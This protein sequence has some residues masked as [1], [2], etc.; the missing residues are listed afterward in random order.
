MCKWSEGSRTLFLFRALLLPQAGQ[1]GPAGEVDASF[2]SAGH[3][4]WWMTLLPK[5][6]EYFSG[7]CSVETTYDRVERIRQF[8]N[9]DYM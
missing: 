8:I 5:V 4:M 9:T 1:P 7:R 6:E 3:K 2:T